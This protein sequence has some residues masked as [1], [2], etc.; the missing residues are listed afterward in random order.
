MHPDTDQLLIGDAGAAGVVWRRPRG[1]SHGGGGR[2]HLGLRGIRSVYCL[3]S[4]VSR[5]YRKKFLENMNI[6]YFY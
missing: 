1:G 4:I 6:I 5:F 2:L 3:G